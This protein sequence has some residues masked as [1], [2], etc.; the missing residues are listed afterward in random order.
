MSSPGSTELILQPK[1]HLL[2]I[3]LYNWSNV[4][5]T[6]AVVNTVSV[7]ATTLDNVT[8]SDISMMVMTPMEILL[9]TKLLLKR[10]QTHQ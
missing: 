6:G 1:D 8:V 9:T 2:L 4:A 5:N 10:I 3:Y 7:S